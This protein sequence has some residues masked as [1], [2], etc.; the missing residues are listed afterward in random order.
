MTVTHPGQYPAESILSIFMFENSTC[1]VHQTG[2]HL[3]L[4]SEQTY[5]VSLSFSLLVGQRKGVAKAKYGTVL[6]MY[7]MSYESHFYKENHSW[8]YFKRP[9]IV[10]PHRYFNCEKLLHTLVIQSSSLCCLE[11]KLAVAKYLLS[12]VFTLRSLES[13]QM[14]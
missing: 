9:E 13:I 3:Y 6:D 2:F 14:I 8:S 7:L 11:D 1:M 5:L 4:P 10:L 12:S